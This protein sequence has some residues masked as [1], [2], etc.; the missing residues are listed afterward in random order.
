M[1][2]RVWVCVRGLVIVLGVGPHLVW[3]GHAA[4]AGRGSA[5]MASIGAGDCRD[6]WDRCSG[7]HQ[8]PRL[9]AGRPGFRN[10]PAYRL[11]RINGGAVGGV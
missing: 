3:V 11:G 6:L 4:L 8:G 7:P 1:P 10:V 9:L 2:S 5:A